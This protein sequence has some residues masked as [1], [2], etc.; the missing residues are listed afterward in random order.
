MEKLHIKHKKENVEK[1]IKD[2]NKMQQYKFKVIHNEDTKSLFCYTLIAKGKNDKIYFY[3]Q[4]NNIHSLN[5][6]LEGLK[7]GLEFKMFLI[8]E[9]E[10]NEKGG[11]INE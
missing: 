11:N 3:K 1:L 10:E 4:L 8:L 9:E 7:S 6:F 5:A 2:I